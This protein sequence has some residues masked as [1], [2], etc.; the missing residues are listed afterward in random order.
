ML[1][2][3]FFSITKITLILFIVYNFFKNA[4]SSVESSRE[5]YYTRIANTLDST[6]KISKTCWFLLKHFLSNKKNLPIPPL[7]RGNRCITDFKEKAK[8]FSSFF[9]NQCSFLN[10]CSSLS[11]NPIYVT[12]KKLR[13]INF[14]AD[15]IEKNHR[16]S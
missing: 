10:N 15:N 8:I 1:N 14:A 2:V 13:T 7:F 12:V 4:F 9:F 11:T 16:K 3:R 5:S 6:Q